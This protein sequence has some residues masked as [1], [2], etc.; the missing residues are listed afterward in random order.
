MGNPEPVD[1]DLVLKYDEGMSALAI[2]KKIVVND[3]GKPL[4][5]IIPYD[6]YID[7]VETYGLD[8]TDEEIEAIEEAEAD[9]EA[10]NRDA[11]ISHEELKRSILECSE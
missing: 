6:V 11:F 5:V 9:F 7:L 3:E 2:E 8:L 1:S 10:G 4:E